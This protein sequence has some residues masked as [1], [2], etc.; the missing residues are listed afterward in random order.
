MET[1]LFA[2]EK[3]E[4]IQRTNLGELI[5]MRFKKNQV[6]NVEQIFFMFS[7]IFQALV[8][9]LGLLKLLY[10]LDPRGSRVEIGKKGNV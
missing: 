9:F 3:K 2:E 10:F 6:R 8:E 5:V 4:K 7:N 1:R